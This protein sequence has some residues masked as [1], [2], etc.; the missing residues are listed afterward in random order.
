MS[1]T[2]LIIRAS[3]DPRN[4]DTFRQEAARWRVTDY[5]YYTQK[6]TAWTLSK[7]MQSNHSHIKTISYKALH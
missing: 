3:E 5:I 6:Y 2:Y 7:M 1:A 4:T